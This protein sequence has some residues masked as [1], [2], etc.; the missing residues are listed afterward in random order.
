MKQ[1][2]R[3]MLIGAA[4]IVA[5]IGLSG[6]AASEQPKSDV[7]AAPELSQEAS[8]K[9]ASAIREIPDSCSALELQPN[10]QFTGGDLGVCVADSLASFGSGKMQLTADSY[11]VVEFTYDPE[12]SF[13]A[14][15]EGSGESTKLVF[16]DG[17]MWVDAGAG[18]IKGDLESDDP[19][20]QLIGAAAQMYRY[21]SDPK[22]TE[23]LIA[24]QPA[25]QTDAEQAL[26]SLPDGSDIDA[27]RITSADEFTW[28]GFPVS[29]AI[30]WFAEDW[31]PVGVQATVAFGGNAETYSQQFYDLGMPVTIRPL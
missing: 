27:Y 31:T 7:S 30:L 1:H 19:Q 10:A 16:Q 13:Q 20:Q 8:A 26:V 6:C 22:Q 3:S 25:W 23:G 2:R 5:A 24:A 15:L 14:T 9:E 11:G 12:Y 21:Y 29:E 4:V 28:N 17:E 18:P